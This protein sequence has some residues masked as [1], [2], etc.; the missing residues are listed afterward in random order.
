VGAGR[1]RCRARARRSKCANDRRST[2]RS[3]DGALALLL[4]SLLLVNFQTVSVSYEPAFRFGSGRTQPLSTPARGSGP[5]AP[6]GYRSPSYVAA[7]PSS[8]L[9]R[10]RRRRRSPERAR[11]LRARLPGQQH[12][13]RGRRGRGC[14]AHVHEGQAA[15]GAGLRA[16][17]HEA[18][19]RGGVPRGRAL[20]QAR[21]CGERARSE[22]AQ[23]GVG[24]G[25]G[26]ARAV[27]QAMNLGRAPAMNLGRAP[28]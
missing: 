5:R 26:H 15:A 20:G 28:G 1:G 9:G 27:L 4:S 19:P 25:G 18:L 21:P 2:A 12:A 8:R 17:Q 11:P 14:P 22:L 24:R 13:Q 10:R 23:D 7:P 16:P 3:F 6:D